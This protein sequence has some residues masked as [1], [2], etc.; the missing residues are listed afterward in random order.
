MRDGDAF[1]IDPLLPLS[2]GAGHVDGLPG[3]M[4]DSVPDRWGRRL[5]AKRYRDERG[6]DGATRMPDEV[7][8]L[9]GVHDGARHGALRY[10]LPGESGRLSD[11]GGVPPRIELPRLM[12]AS[13]EVARDRDRAED[14]K[15][16]LDAGSGSLGGAR[17]KASVKDDER[18]LLAKFSHPGDEWHVMAWEHFALTIAGAAGL[19]VP[20]HQL[21]ALGDD[22]ALLLERFDREGSLAQGLRIPYMSAMTLLGA[23]D[24]ERRDY[25]EVAEAIPELTDAPE[26]DLRELFARAALSVVLH[27]TDDHLRNLGFV[28]TRGSW[29]LAPCFDINPNPNLAEG[30]VT[31]L[32][33]EEGVGEVTGLQALAEFCGLNPQAASGEVR[34]I[35]GAMRG[36]RLQARRCGCRASEVDLFAPVFE[37]R[38]AA[39][40]SAFAGS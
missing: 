12:A 37:D 8:Y 19:S 1:S 16:L 11:E 3:A 14:V 21:V 27:N 36:W 25:A 5:I 28:R 32:L 20:W 4:R 31:T 29:R 35:L 22:S 26:D 39:L 13:N 17:P 10:A 40:E 9:L 33:G 34:E 38:C 6:A 2:A 24:G 30:R 15:A 7:D 23:T 18:M